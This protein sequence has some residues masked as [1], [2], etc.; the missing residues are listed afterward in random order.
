VREGQ[1]L[2]PVGLYSFVFSLGA[3]GAATIIVYYESFE[4]GRL[5]DL[6]RWTSEHQKEI[7]AIQ[8]KLWDLWPV[9]RR[10]VY[11][12]DFAGSFSLKSVLPALVPEMSYEDM[13][14]GDG[15]MAG[16]AWKKFIDPLTTVREKNCLRK[17]LL[18]YCAQDTLG[19]VRVLELLEAAADKH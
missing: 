2:A 5:T 17:A 4:R 11:H 12:P 1:Q 3:R 16:I 10:N 7:I 19:I 13:E 15:L 9:I 8:S 18:D 14:I 6:I